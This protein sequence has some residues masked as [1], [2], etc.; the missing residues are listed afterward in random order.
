MKK[1]APLCAFVHRK[2]KLDFIFFLYSDKI[3]KKFRAFY[4]RPYRP[5]NHKQTRRSSKSGSA[6]FFFDLKNYFFF[7]SAFHAFI[8]SRRAFIF[9]STPSSVGR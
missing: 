4:S 6:V 1:A 2:K 3:S 7:C 8:S 9:P 5:Q